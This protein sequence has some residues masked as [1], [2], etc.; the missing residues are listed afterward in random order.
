MILFRTST[1]QFQITKG[2]FTISVVEQL[3]LYSQTVFYFILLVNSFDPTPIQFLSAKIPK[4]PLKVIFLSQEPRSPPASVAS[5][6]SGLH[7]SSGKK[8]GPLT[9]LFLD[10]VSHSAVRIRILEPKLEN[11]YRYSIQIR[12]K[13]VFNQI[14]L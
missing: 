1:V 2:K 3:H 8:G 14:K 11:G 12:H 6:T 7:F 10:M 13:S 5:P 9:I 4:E